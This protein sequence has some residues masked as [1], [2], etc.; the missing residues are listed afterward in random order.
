MSS[1]SMFTCGRTPTTLSSIWNLSYSH[2]VVVQLSPM[3]VCCALAL[4]AWFVMHHFQVGLLPLRSTQSCPSD[5]GNCNA[6]VPMPYRWQ[7]WLVGGALVGFV[8]GLA[9]NLVMGQVADLHQPSKSAG[10]TGEG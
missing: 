7:L 10:V 1:R 6:R 9:D 3:A 8:I 4:A 5:F 2:R